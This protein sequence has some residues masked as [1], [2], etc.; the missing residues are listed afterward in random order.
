MAFLLRPPTPRMNV[1]PA[2]PRRAGDCLR[3]DRFIPTLHPSASAVVTG[4]IRPP[5]P[6][7]MKSPIG[8]SFAE[9]YPQNLLVFNNKPG[10]KKFQPVVEEKQERKQSRVHFPKYDVNAPLEAHKFFMQSCWSDDAVALV[11]GGSILAYE[12]F[13]KFSGLH[14][15][16]RV[17]L[18]ITDGLWLQQHVFLLMASKRLVRVHFSKTEEKLPLETIINVDN[19]RNTR[20]VGL[21]YFQR[22]LAVAFTSVLFYFDDAGA[23]KAPTATRRFLD[24]GRTI[25][26]MQLMDGKCAVALADGVILILS[27]SEKSLPVL[28]E[29]PKQDKDSV[30]VLHWNKKLPHF[31]FCGYDSKKNGFKIW[32]LDLGQVYAKGATPGPVSGIS[33]RYNSDIV[34]VA[35]RANVEEASLM[36]WKA[37]TSSFNRLSLLHTVLY[38]NIENINI[39]LEDDYTPGFAKLLDLAHRSEVILM[40]TANMLIQ[41]KIGEEHKTPYPGL[42][43]SVFRNLA[44]SLRR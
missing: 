13:T 19:I 30:G 11:V 18:E 37:F 7:A 26:K 4:G 20:P 32:D 41:D 28:Q 44:L 40:G 21:S 10:V 1:S 22:H 31:L 9:I 3:G 24:K 14:S 27:M 2:T 34:L 16:I 35:I 33:Y 39:P 6:Q 23:I 42:S 12:N 15:S 8:K 17:P 36:M 5:T 38:E 25:K 29:I 43:D